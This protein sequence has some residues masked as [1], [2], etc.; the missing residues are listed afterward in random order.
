MKNKRKQRQSPRHKAKR[1]RKYERKDKK[2]GEPAQQA[3]KPNNP[4]EENRKIEEKQTS[5]KLFNKMTQNWQIRTYR[6]TEPT[7]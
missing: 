5:M 7:E 2:I 4:K 6:L 3:L 1:N